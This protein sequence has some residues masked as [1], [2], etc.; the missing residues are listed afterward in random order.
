LES[1]IDPN[2]RNQELRD[3]QRLEYCQQWQWLFAKTVA[4]E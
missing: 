3:G 1:N 4:E 2:F